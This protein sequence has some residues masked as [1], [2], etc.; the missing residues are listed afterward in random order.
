MRELREAVVH[1]FRLIVSRSQLL[2]S[3]TRVELAKRYSGSLFGKLWIFLY[4][5]LLLSIYLFLFLVVFK[6]RFPGYSDFGFVL[7]IFTGL[8]PFIGLSDAIS[9]GVLCLK[10]NMQLVKNAMIPLELIPIRTVAV[11][12]VAMF[13]SLALLLVLLL[14]SA[15]PHWT[16]LAL[17]IVVVLQLAFH[18][19]IVFFLSPIALGFPDIGYFTNLA[20]LFLMFISP[21]AFRVDMVPEPMRI[22]VYLNPVYYQTV[23]YRSVL[24]DGCLPDLMPALVYVGICFGTFAFGSLFF[25]RFQGILAD[26]E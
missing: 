9:G 26:Y 15:P 18:T 5:A 13:A 17:P 22:L 19:G 24:L 7:Y 21:I 14:V 2:A 20:L 16:M 23:V 3:I 11:A 6:V 4:P 1:M 12:S 10:Q 8:V 25:R